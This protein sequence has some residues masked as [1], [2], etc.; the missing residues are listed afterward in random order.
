MVIQNILD[1][2]SACD[3]PKFD[4]SSS[5]FYLLFFD[6]VTKRFDTINVLIIVAYFISSHT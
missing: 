2:V 4:Q 5:Y 1:T 3:I 6:P